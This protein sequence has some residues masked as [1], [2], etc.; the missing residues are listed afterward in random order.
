ML[1]AI[2]GDI[3]GS[4]YE[5]H[6]IKSKNFELFTDANCFTDDTILTC[7]T[8]EWL[9]SD[10]KPEEILKK[11]GTLY[12]ER[13]YEN[14]KI[15]AFGSGFTNWL[16]TGKPYRAK[17]NGCVM[18]LSPIPL[19][20]DDLE[21][22]LNKAVELTSITHNHKESILATRV[23]IETMYMA[24][25]GIDVPVIKNYIT[26][27][28]GYDLSKSVD[29]IR[30][31]Y[32]KFYTSCKNSVPQAIIC[33]LDANSYEDAIRNAVSLGGDSDT[34]ACM[35]GGIA[36]VRFGVPNDI[37]KQAIVYMDNRVLNIVNRFYEK[38]NSID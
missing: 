30:P 10:K 18:R 9:L 13:T 35:A 32:N 21:I 11:W 25:K 16:E 29:E 23:Y 34:L 8:A 1:G 4:R 5:F 7:A 22:A 38:I 37:K 3:I 14:G 27:K 15:G 28:Y 19:M 17:T 33:A 20:V 2:I 6:N 12:K 24:K 36:E 31:S 26:H